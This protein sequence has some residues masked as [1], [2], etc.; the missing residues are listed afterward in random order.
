[1]KLRLISLVIVGCAMFVT[2]GAEAR[3]DEDKETIKSLEGR[4][5]RQP[6]VVSSVGA[7]L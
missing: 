3:K 5:E 7:S 1:M 2:T 4:Y 6:L